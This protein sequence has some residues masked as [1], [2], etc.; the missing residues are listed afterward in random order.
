MAT[1]QNTL[2]EATAHLSGITVCHKNEDIDVYGGRGTRQATLLGTPVGKDGWLGNPYRLDQHGDRAEVI[3]RYVPD[4]YA[5]LEREPEFR[6]AVKQLDGKR[7]GCWCR[8]SHEN[9]P[10]CHLDVID[11]FLRGGRLYVRRFLTEELGVVPDGDG[12][13]RLR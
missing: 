1:H 12:V 3:A 6:A 13:V 8:H 4:F 7:V 11:Q 5:R 2:I 9:S 10:H